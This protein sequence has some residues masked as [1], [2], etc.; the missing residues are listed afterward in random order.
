MNELPYEHMREGDGLDPKYDSKPKPS[1]H[2]K[3]TLQLCAQVRDVLCFVFSDFEETVYVESVT[4][5]PNSANLLVTLVTKDDVDKITAKIYKLK[6]MIRCEVASAI[7]RKKVPQ[8]VY[9]VNNLGEQ[10]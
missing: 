9:A 8:L 1:R 2:H 6:G 3:K 7:N 5:L 4:P 10:E